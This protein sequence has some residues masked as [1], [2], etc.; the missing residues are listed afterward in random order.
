MANFKRPG[1]YTEETLAAQVATSSSVSISA[2]A[3]LGHVDRGPLTATTVSSWSEFQKHYGDLDTDFAYAAFLF[4]ANGGSRL[5]VARVEG[6]G[7]SMATR[8]LNDRDASP[9]PTL[10]VDAINPGEWGNDI[11]VEITGESGGDRFNLIVYVGGST[12]GFIKERWLDLTMDTADDRYVETIINHT[13]KGSA[14]I[15]VADQESGTAAPN[16]T[17]ALQAA[18]VLTGGANGSTPSEASVAAETSRLDTITE[19]FS[20]NCPGLTDATAVGTVIT[21][22]E[23]RDDVFVVCD[24]VAGDDVATAITYKGSL[25]TSS[26]AALYYPRVYFS[27]PASSTPGAVKLLAPGGAIMGQYARVDKQRNVAKA[28]AGL[29]VNLAGAVSLETKL[30]NSDLDDLNEAHVNAIRNVPGA[31]V[32][33]MGARTLKKRQVDKYVPVRRTLTYLKSSLK[34]LTAFAVFEPNDEVLWSQISVAVGGFLKE[35]WQDGGLRGATPTQAYYVK[36][37]S[38]LNTEQVISEG[39][40]I[41]EVGVALQQPAEFVVIQIGQWQGGS[42]AAES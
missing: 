18:T 33:V 16:D 15:T 42:S 19:P 3:L 39:K 4:F 27:D 40:V 38:E 29:S 5:H 23:G 24:P 30:T 1:V 2:G 37:D 35:F 12:A 8:T 28:P 11:Y 36:C 31:G 10:T 17:P 22:A 41:V 25:G 14:Y 20:L 9:Q 26:Y 7:A 13:T 34:D 32:V 6:S 21:Y